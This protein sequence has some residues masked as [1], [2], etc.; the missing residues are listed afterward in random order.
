MTAAYIIDASRTPR[1]R[2]KK[3]KGALSGIHPQELL[4]QTLNDLAEKA[5]IDKKDVDDVI[6]GCVTQ[7]GEQGA[8]V[9]RNAVLAADWPE[10]VTGVTL[11][12][13][14][15]SGLQSVNFAA[16]GVMSGQ[17]AG[18]GVLQGLKSLGLRIAL[19]DFGTGYSSLSYLRRFPIDELK[20]DQSFLRNLDDPG[21]A[22]LVATI[23]AMGRGLGFEVVAEGVET[24]EQLQFLRQHGCHRLQ[25]YLFSPPLTAGK[26][27]R[28]WA[29]WLPEHI[30]PD[31]SPGR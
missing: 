20:I 21:D 30:P 11:N 24:G 6:V 22:A 7:A 25:G 29:Q 28:W 26:F 4:A 2:G 31:A 18:L 5:K 16:M 9:A 23:I 10:E 1:G 12:R 13:F 15:G 3:D 19:D 27:E 8:S 17:Q 14:C